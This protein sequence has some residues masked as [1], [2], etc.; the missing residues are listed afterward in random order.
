MSSR[1]ELASISRDL[2]ESA[3]FSWVFLFSRKECKRSPG[4]RFRGNRAST[5]SDKRKE[6]HNSLTSGKKRTFPRNLVWCIDTLIENQQNTRAQQLP[7]CALV[8]SVETPSHRDQNQVYI[9]AAGNVNTHTH[10]LYRY[11]SRHITQWP[12]PPNSCSGVLTCLS[13][14][15]PATPAT[16][17]GAPAA[18]AAPVATATTATLSFTGP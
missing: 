9:E 15:T 8:W 18:P 11:T 6:C 5:V 10:P 7:I 3:G 2:R 1:I 12:S 13:S 14:A 4:F 17:A 16:P